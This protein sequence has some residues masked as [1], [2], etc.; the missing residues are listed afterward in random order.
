MNKHK[1]RIVFNKNRGQMMAV[2]ESASA[3]SADSGKAASG[4]TT[5]TTA[6]VGLLLG[7]ALGGS[8]GLVSLTATAQVVANT[9]AP[10]N[11]RP[12][13]TTTASGV[14][15]VNIQTAV[16]GVSRNRYT[17]FDVGAGGVIL[18]NSPVNSNTKL[19]G[20]VAGNNNLARLL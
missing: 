10:A 14:T 8:L 5:L 17:Q 19:A 2:A 1:H 6:G 16:G 20:W 3:H 15:Q 11:Q 18:N 9:A 4:Q 12:E 13:V 7:I